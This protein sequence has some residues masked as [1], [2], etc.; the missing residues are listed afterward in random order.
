MHED[1]NALV[2]R[3]SILGHAV[4]LQDLNMTGKLK[5]RLDSFGTITS[6][7]V[8]ELHSNSRGSES[9]ASTSHLHSSKVSTTP[10]RHSG[11][12]HTAEDPALS[13]SV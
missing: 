11:T 9:W 5:R 13:Y 3:V 1:E 2:S 4:L 12:R 6:V 10:L 8:A 7:M